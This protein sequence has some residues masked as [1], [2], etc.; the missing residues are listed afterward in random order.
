MADYLDASIKYL[1]FE[2]TITLCKKCAYN[3]DIAG[4]DLCPICKKNYKPMQYETCVD[5]LP[6]GERKNQIKEWIEVAKKL[7]QMHKDMGID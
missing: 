5:C 4:K 1:S 3:E 6:D 7:H 2:D